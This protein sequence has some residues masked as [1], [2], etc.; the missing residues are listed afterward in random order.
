MTYLLNSDDKHQLDFIEW[1]GDYTIGSGFFGSFKDSQP[2]QL[3]LKKSDNLF[4]ILGVYDYL[5]KPYSDNPCRF[6]AYNCDIKLHK[7]AIEYLHPDL[8]I[9]RAVLAELKNNGGVLAGI[10]MMEFIEK[11]FK[12][13]SLIQP[14]V[15]MNKL[16]KDGICEKIGKEGELG[17]LLKLL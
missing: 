15:A 11:K 12:T 17:A 16:V 4:D 2:L 6:I 9:R 7:E 3:F 14:L 5:A 8:S 10:D 1:Y 13:P